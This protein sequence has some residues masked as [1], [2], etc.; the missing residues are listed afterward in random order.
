[1]WYSISL[2]MSYVNKI[3]SNSKKCVKWLE[4]PE[5]KRRMK[6]S[7]NIPVALVDVFD[8]SPECDFK[9]EDLIT[10]TEYK[11][12]HGN[13]NKAIIKS[14]NPNL[15]VIPFKIRLDASGS[16]L[17][18]SCIEKLY[19]VYS[20]I[21][22]G[23][24]KGVDYSMT[25]IFYIKN[26]LKVLDLDSC[27]WASDLTKKGL[28]NLPSFFKKQIRREIFRADVKSE[29]ALEFWQNLSE[30]KK[31]LEIIEKLTEINKVYAPAGN[32]DIPLANMII[33]AKG[34]KVVGALD[35]RGKNMS[36]YTYATKRVRGDFN[37]YLED[38]NLK[39]K[40]SDELTE[41]SYS[42]FSNAYAFALSY[43]LGAKTPKNIKRLKR[44]KEKLRD[45]GQSLTTLQKVI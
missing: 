19:D 37:F 21:K 20:E 15:N 23:K 25:S 3:R 24:I 17:M 36:P 44:I 22:K 39:A 7:L 40:L 6:K 26:M 5:N 31:E 4:L 14:Y 42:C 32:D 27:S 43:P 29:K 35:R 28:A 41:N 34:V 10:G 38:G 2:N 30:V 13:T 16:P 11:A 12:V 45:N 18:S 9:F 1:M 8:W 33:F